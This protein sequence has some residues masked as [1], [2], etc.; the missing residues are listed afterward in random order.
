MVKNQSKGLKITFV[1]IAELKKGNLNL[2]DKKKF[3][4]N[5]KCWM[6]DWKQKEVKIHF[7]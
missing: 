2:R 1:K 4:P 3:K 6:F 5:L 7:E